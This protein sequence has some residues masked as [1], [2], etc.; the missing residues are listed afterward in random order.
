MKYCCAFCKKCWNHPVDKCIFCGREITQIKETQYRVIGFT[1]VFIPSTGNEKV[2]YYVNI[3][4]DQK[5]YKIIQKTFEKHDIGDIIDFQENKKSDQT[6]GVIGTGLLGTQIASYLIQ[7]G[8][9][10]IVKTR[11][12]VRKSVTLSKIQKQISKRLSDEEVKK[13]LQNLL[14]TTDYSDLTHCDIVIEAATEDIVIKEEIFRILSEICEPQTIFATNSSSLSIDELS[15]ASNRPEKCIG[16][17]FFNPVHRMDLVEVVIGKSTSNDTISVI[18]EIVTRLNKRP[19]VVKNSPGY[20]VNRLLL[21]QINDAIYLLE[22]GVASKEDI[23]NAIK[24]GLNHPMG[25]FELADFI[26]LDICLSILEVL[27]RELQDPHN[28]PAPILYKLVEQGKLG[29]KTGEGFYSY[30]KVAR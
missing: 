21:P 4:E 6:I 12:E 19:I 27:H 17:H 11:S 13:S 14:I 23:D 20:V 5:K 8:Y 7:Y 26:G 30:G 1:E 2:P 3:L 9:P 10:T 18:K 28:K 25:P 16:M 29:F 24:L 22:E 15:A